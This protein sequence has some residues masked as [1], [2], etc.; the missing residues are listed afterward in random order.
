MARSTRKQKRKKQSTEVAT[1]QAERAQPGPDLGEEI[2]SW[3]AWPLVEQKRKAVILIVSTIAFAVLI[4]I[5]FDWYSM[6]LALGISF[7][8]YSGF[9]VP[10][11][12]TIAEYGIKYHN[13]ITHATRLWDDFADYQV[14]SDGIQL[15]YYR[16]RVRDRLLRGIFVYYGSEDPEQIRTLIEGVMASDQE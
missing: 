12:Y 7:I 15:N 14:F 10:S 13:W 3:R 6:L 1:S 9:V 2:I 11:S 4:R 16:Q 8:A 5:I